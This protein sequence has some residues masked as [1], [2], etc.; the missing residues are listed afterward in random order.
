[1]QP[2]V[3]SHR[4]QSVLQHVVKEL[5]LTLTLSDGDCE[6]SLANNQEM[7]RNLADMMEVE[8]VANTDRE[9]S[10]FTFRNKR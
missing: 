3:Y 9:I 7:L 6:I 2:I 4:I 8:F 1:M 5:G 10:I